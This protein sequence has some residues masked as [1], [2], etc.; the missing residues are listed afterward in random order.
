MEK[1]KIKNKKKSRWWENSFSYYLHNGSALEQDW[2]RF[3]KLQCRTTNFIFDHFRQQVT[4]LPILVTHWMDP[5][6]KGEWSNCHE[7]M[8]IW[9]KYMPGG[10]KY[11]LKKLPGENEIKSNRAE[12]AIMKKWKCHSNK[13][14]EE[15]NI[16]WNSQAGMRQNPRENEVATPK[17]WK[18]N[19]NNCQ[20]EWNIAWNSCQTGMRQNTRENEVAATK[21]WKF[22]WNKCWEERNI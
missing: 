1:N 2:D 9:L 4:W 6:R 12:V 17:K 5:E 8:K 11:C 7:E 15:W 3:R 20:E 19:W 22:N 18:F 21:K 13:C 14:Q 16:V 10:M